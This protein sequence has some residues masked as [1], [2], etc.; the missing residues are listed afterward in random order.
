MSDPRSRPSSSSTGRTRTRRVGTARSTPFGS[1]PPVIAAANPLRGIERR[2]VPERVLDRI[3]GRS[4]SPGT[5]TAGRHEPRG[6][7]NPTSHALVYVASFLASPAR[8]LSSSSPSSRAPSSPALHSRSYPT[9]AVAWR[10]TLH[11][12]GAFPAL[13][14]GDVDADVAQQMAVTQ[15]PLALAAFEAP[16]T[17][18]A[19]SSIESWVLAADQDLAVPTSC[20]TGWRNGRTPHLVE[21]TRPTRSRLAPGRH[22]ASPRAAQKTAR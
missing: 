20:R 7:G 8:R 6:D 4:S 14:A 10:P 12:P 19:W 11:R 5:R 15:R 18:A 17:R 13:F 9:P 16:V 1:R 2:C 21:T 22:P 3:D